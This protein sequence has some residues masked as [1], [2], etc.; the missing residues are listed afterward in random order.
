MKMDKLT[1]EYCWSV[2]LN[3]KF[4]EKVK[5]FTA[6]RIRQALE[7]LPLS[8]RYLKY[9]RECQKQNI[10]AHMDFFNPIPCQQFY[11]AP[12]GGIGGG[13]IGRSFT[14]DFCRFQLT[15]GIYEHQTAEANMFTVCIRKRHK[16]TYQQVL[17]IRRP[18][19]TSKG[20]KAWNMGYDGEHARYSTVYPESWTVYDL[21]GQNVKLTCHQISPII[22]HDYHDSSLPVGLFNWTV[23]NN[24]NEEIEVSIMFTWQ[25]GTSSNQFELTNVRSLPIETYQ[26]YGIN[27]T[28]VKI[29]QLY[30]K[31]LLEYCISAKNTENCKVT[32]DCQFDPTNIES[33]TTL[34][35]DLLQD[36][37]LDNRKFVFDNRKEKLAS[38]VCA[39]VKVLENSNENIDFSLVWN[40][41]VICFNSKNSEVGARIEYNRFYSRY[42]PDTDRDCSANISCY[43]L[44]KRSEW[45]KRIA[46]WRKPIFEDKSL[47]EWYKRAIFNELY[48]ISDGGTVWL[49]I[50]EDPNCKHQLVRDFGRFAYLEGHEYRMYNTYDVHFYASFALLK[51]FP[52]LH[53]SLQYEFADTIPK[54]SEKNDFQ[55]LMD[56]KYGK[57]KSKDSLP[58]DIGDPNRQP[59]LNVNV[60][61]S[62]DTKDWRDLN[63]KFI[64]TVYRDYHYLK[65][66]EYL[67]HMWTY[68]KDLM[69]TVQSHDTDGDGLIDSEGWPD[70]TYDAWSVTGASA[71]C[72]GLHIATLKTVCEIAKLMKDDEIFKKYDKILGQAKESYNKK[73]WNGKYY[74]YDCSNSSYNDSIMSDMCCGHFFL[75]CSGL[76]YE[77]FEQE[78]IKSCLETIFDYNVLK[79]ADGKG[80]VINGMRPDGKIDK[81]SMQSEEVWIGTA[82]CLSSLFIFEGMNE[83]AWTIVEGMYSLLYDR[84]GLA[85]QTPEALFETNTYR[86]LGYMRPLAIWSIQYA[87]DLNK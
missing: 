51:L 50:K 61:N 69:V 43:S 86:S 3:H 87:L 48:F 14:G 63:L 73:L 64:L 62:H 20:L 12:I 26:N 35:M 28:G 66:I 24:N 77:A 9:W 52:K 70:Q 19:A 65:D 53:L 42:F 45:Q 67:K 85:F 2:K 17:T 82:A 6:P 55:F 15:P 29:E 13:S 36:G 39:Q 84:L 68:I 41:P 72:G 74:K 11:G 27:I 32:Y 18:T 54:E 47:P 59:W 1:E 80:G 49:D 78:K 4:T 22:P 56:G 38:A 83:K 46:D 7:F 25:S 21:P 16:T 40:M 37:K 75:R 58:H 30:N 71:Y 79:F 44:S 8:I 34:W 81:T 60:Y 10:Q 23:E 33:G 31:M 57:Q 5:P 76:N